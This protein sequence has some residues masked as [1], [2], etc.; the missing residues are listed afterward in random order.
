MAVAPGRVWQSASPSPN[1]SPLS[2]CFLLTA[3]SLMY[4][5]MAG[6]P[7]ADSPRRKNGRKIARRRGAEGLECGSPGVR[8]PKALFSVVI[9]TVMM[10]ASA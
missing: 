8:S 1:D 4:A 2:Q 5:T 6:P 3:R 7:K 9:L 10:S